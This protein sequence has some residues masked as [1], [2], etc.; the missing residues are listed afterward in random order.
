MPNHRSRIARADHDRG[1]RPVRFLL[2][3]LVLALAAC[4]P[5]ADG[6]DHCDMGVTRDIAFTAPNAED[7]IIARVFGASCD[8]AVGLYVIYDVDG[9]PIWS[10]TSP[11]QRAFGDVFATEDEA[12]MRAFLERWAQPEVSTTTT[13]TEWGLLAP[14][15]TTLDRTTYE[16]IRARNLPMLCHYSGT[17]RET[18]VF[19]EP[20]AGGAG[21][22]LDRE[23]EIEE[24]DP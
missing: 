10:W 5:R 21:H 16:D 20:A 2:A 12:Y 13:A 15:Q 24:T 9:H 23:V 4:G 7:T 6:G 8:K 22:F 11:L 17:G 18:C 3:V 1:L 14:G 19:W